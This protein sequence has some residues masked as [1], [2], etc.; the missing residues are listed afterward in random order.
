MNQRRSSPEKS[1]A[2]R[3]DGREKERENAKGEGKEKKK[4]ILSH[5]G[6]HGDYCASTVF[7]PRSGGGTPLKSRVVH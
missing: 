4:S 2:D 7:P 5:R 6:N 1:R 3:I